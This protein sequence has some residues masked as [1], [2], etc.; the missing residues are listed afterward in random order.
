MKTLLCTA[1]LLAA[2]GSSAATKDDPASALASGP[3]QPQGSLVISD[4]LADPAFNGGSGNRT[5]DFN[6]GN[7]RADAAMRVFASS[8]GGYWV[9]GVHGGGG[10]PVEIAIAKLNVDGS[11][12]TGYNT[13]GMK[14]ITTT[15]TSLRD[16]A[17]GPNDALYF[18]GTGIAPT[19][20]DTDI[21]VICVDSTGA[22]C[23]GFG[24]DGIKSASLDLGNV[25]HH[26]D[27]PTRITYFG[28]SLY[29]AG[30]ADTGVAASNFAV[31]VL[32]LSSASGARDP[33]FG[34]TPGNAGL[35]HTNIDHVPNG[36][37]VAFDVLAYAPAPFAPR[38]VLVGQT[39]RA[40]TD[41]DGFVM[42]LDGVNGSEDGFL[43][44]TVFADL[45]ISKQDT[46]LRVMRLRN[47]GFVVAGTAQDDSVS[48]TQYQLLMSAYNDNGVPDTR[49]GDLGDGTL[50]K[51]VLS[52]TAIPYGLAERD[53]NR[54][55]VVGLNIKDDL[56][57]DGHPVQGVM[58][59]GSDGNMG[60]A[61]A[62][63]DFAGT[64]RNS[65]GLD[66]IMDGNVV[67]TAGSRLWSQASNDADM[68]VG[69]FVANDSIFADAFGGHLSD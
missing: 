2:A 64:P 4:L 31:F 35:F 66:L 37:D 68:T 43:D 51:L 39:Q 3:F 53:G 54:D 14:T 48:P 23:A 24:T 19:F 57:G 59:F 58:Q 7:A 13:T 47:G 33:V 42:S 10:G 27:T 49:F 6:N 9:A 20:T 63:L 41:I 36:R 26:N 61:V 25:D 15:L 21:Y 17:I 5:V 38:V 56:F 1:L 16:V 22:L 65:Q 12:D 29:I 52:G 44:D 60:H 62:T 50:H 55:I 18:V 30:E 67:L 69:R 32:K 46:L 34:N 8:D 40:G 45:G 11:F 28:S